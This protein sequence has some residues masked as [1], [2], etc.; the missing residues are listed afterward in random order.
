MIY[1]LQ[2]TYKKSLKYYLNV[3]TGKD[4]KYKYYSPEH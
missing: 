1:Q 3:D 2:Y 4:P